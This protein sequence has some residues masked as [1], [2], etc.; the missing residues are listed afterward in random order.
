MESMPFRMAD[1]AALAPE[2][3]VMAGAS[4]VLLLAAT[5][6]ARRNAHNFA[7]ISLVTVLAALWSV[8]RLWGDAT[9]GS[10]F[11]SGQLTLDPFGLFF[12]SLFLV[13]AALAIGASIRFL[14]DTAEDQ[15]EYYFFLLTAVA[16]M[17]VMARGIDFVTLFVG[18]ELQALSVYVLVGYLKG[19]R[20]SNEGALKYFILGG[21]SSAIFVFA[22]SLL[23]AVTGSTALAAV[24]DGLGAL[25]PD[26]GGSLALVALILLVVSLGFKV[27]AVPFHVWAPDAYSGAPTPVALF[28]TV[29]SKAAAFALLLRVLFVA[30]APMQHQWV[31]LLAVLSAGTMT[32]GNVAAITQDNIKRLLAYSSIAHAGYALMGV[33]AATAYG[34]EA[35]L[36]YLLA[37]TFMNVGAWAV[38]ILLRREGV[39]SDR[40]EDFAGVAQRSWWAFGAMLLFMLSLGGIPP[41][42]GFLGKWYI[43]AAAI[44]GGWAWLAVVGVINT[45]VSLYY[46]L[47]VV[48]VM[49]MR[50][51]PA[52]T[53]LVRS[54]P[55]NLTL[56]AAALMTLVGGMYGGR[57][58]AWVQTSTLPF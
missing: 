51:A 9:A 11:F 23:Y 39:P 22:V 53:S 24:G 7:W 58:F 12:A 17:L 35:A 57:L 43:F 41:T 28:I 4:V 15:P 30:V 45:A 20:L 36:F 44:D 1:L 21:F 6:W 10:S 16:G 31:L 47:R 14:D 37:Y 50:E 3:V 8:T 5:S 38:V 49:C 29:A 42:L 46:Y 19:D 40:L 33:V 54:L 52:E 55:L 56:A 13:T 48:V 25:G 27:A 18:L 2:L 26:G 32:L 34:M